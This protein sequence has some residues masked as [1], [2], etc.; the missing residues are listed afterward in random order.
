[1]G[2]FDKKS[3]GA[4]ESRARIK[5]P[6]YK[7][8]WFIVIVVLAVIGAFG[9]EE[10]KAEDAAKQDNKQVVKQDVQ[11]KE[12][13]A[14]SKLDVTGELS[15]EFKNGKAITTIKTNAIDGSI[16]E[17]MV[18]DAEF[19]SVSDFITIE[20]GIGTK[21]FD[22]NKEWETGY[23]AATSMMRFNLEEHTQPDHVKKLYG[24][25]GEKIQGIY[26]VENNVGG[27]NVN[28]KVIQKEYPDEATVKEKQNELF[29]GAINE[30]I[31]SSNGV[32]LGIQPHFED[33]EWNSVAVTVSD[34]WYNSAEHEKER[35]AETIGD[36]VKIL[37]INAG[38]VVKD[39]NVSVY[40]Y[41]SYQ[42]EL[43]SPK[44]L[45]GYKIKR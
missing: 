26:A 10:D 24:E 4:K 12:E 33:N 21:E 45:G 29:F 2:L 6:F 36:T 13:K 39:A 30:L 38:K 3:V 14:A 18:M 20:N 23:L 43:A 44:I 31:D 37:V 5:K 17:T 42:K 9:G 1:M 16:F 34:S 28:L 8:W 40:F 25:N 19:N 32:L 22:E 35:F 27:N 15:I 11:E 41:D 7:R